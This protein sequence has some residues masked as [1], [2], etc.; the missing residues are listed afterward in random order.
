[1]D[2]IIA[3]I[4]FGAVFG[5][6]PM[7]IFYGG[8]FVHYLSYYEIKE[9]FNSFFMQ[10]LN[11]YLYCGFGLFSGIA[12]IINTN[13]LRFVYLACMLVFCSTLIPNIGINMGEK[14]F[15]KNAR[16]NVDGQAKPVKLI[17][18]DNKKIYY[19]FNN[20]PKIQRLDLK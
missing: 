14:L 13:F 2:K 16:I 5:L 8:I 7:I 6:F 17:Y 4:F 19:K 10:N 3:I 12:F 20:N 1:M 11:L 9:Y 18:K 15:A